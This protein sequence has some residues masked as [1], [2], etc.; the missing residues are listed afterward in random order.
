MGQG[1][2]KCTA[3]LVSRRKKCPDPVSGHLSLLSIQTLYQPPLVL[4]IQD[5]FLH[6]VLWNVP[7]R[8]VLPT[9]TICAH[10]PL[11]LSTD[12]QVGDSALLCH[13]AQY[14]PQHMYYQGSELLHME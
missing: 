12:N 11:P 6:H 3:L 8:G 2:E 5:P 13:G 10:L 14:T 4:F 1:Q 7:T 9:L